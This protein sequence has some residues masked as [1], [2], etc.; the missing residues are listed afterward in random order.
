M[1]TYIEV[2]IGV[3]SCA[4]LLLPSVLLMF[5]RYEVRGRAM[6]LVCELLSIRSYDLKE[7]CLIRRAFKTL[8]D[9]LLKIAENSEDLANG[10]VG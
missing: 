8:R 3:P 1:S 6:Y 4:L 9:F 5:R 7:T 2:C 10:V